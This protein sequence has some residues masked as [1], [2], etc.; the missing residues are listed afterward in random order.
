MTC[1]RRKVLELLCGALSIL[2]V[3]GTCQ[4]DGVVLQLRNGDRVTGTIVSEDSGQLT[5]SNSWSKELVIPVSQIEWRE[6]VP[7]AANPPAASVAK[8][9]AVPAAA[10]TNAAPL[11]SNGW[12]TI[13]VP[14]PPLPM[15]PWYKYWKVDVLLG[16]SMIRGATDSELY[17]GKAAFT[18]SHPYLSDPKLFFRNILTYVADYGET[19]GT[20]SANDMSGSSKTDF[21]INKGIYVYNLGA[22]GYDI[23]RGIRLHWEEGPGVGYHVLKLT[24]LVANAEAGANYQQNNQ[25]DDSTVRSVFF[26][27]AQDFNW[28]ITPRM[29]LTEKYE[30]FPRIDLHQ[31]RWRFESS[32]AYALME[33]IS[34]N[35]GVV[36]FY[37]TAP[38]TGV[39][40]NDFEFRTA[41]GIKF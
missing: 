31:Y 28:K 12:A 25:T 38:A 32:L 21:D 4:A 22:V 7:S 36:D 34:F 24:N 27:L 11:S 1:H 37:D 26:R 30:F 8:T 33:N 5:L 29:T 6:L 19:D 18:Y 3:C 41:L 2:L 9:N 17:Y 39:P 35:L 15:L 13:T 10:N 40:N 23:I 14:P 16:S 20:L